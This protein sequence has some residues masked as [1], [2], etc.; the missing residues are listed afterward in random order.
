MEVSRRRTLNL[1]KIASGA[2][3]GMI[4]GGIYCLVGEVAKVIDR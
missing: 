1:P 2:V 3:V 4:V